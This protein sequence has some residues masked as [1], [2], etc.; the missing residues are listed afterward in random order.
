MSK[1]VMFVIAVDIDTHEV[2]VDD[3]V[4]TARFSGN[5]A[6]WDT[7]SEEWIA[8]PNDELY[9]AALDILNAKLD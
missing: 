1:Q 4:F 7:E 9:V 6:A 5:E 2:M 8:D 3:E